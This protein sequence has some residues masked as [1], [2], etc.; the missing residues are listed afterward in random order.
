MV[1]FHSGDGIGCVFESVE[2]PEGRVEE[3][4]PALQEVGKGAGTSAGAAGMVCV[5][6][7]ELADLPALR[8]VGRGAGASAGGIWMVRVLV[9]EL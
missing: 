4:R 9:R 7:R 6:V 2:G 1:T 8:D 5:L 3:G